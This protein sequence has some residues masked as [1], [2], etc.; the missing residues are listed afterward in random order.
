ME[1]I[2][3]LPQVE[4]F[5]ND[6]VDILFEQEYFGFQNDA[7]IYIKKIKIFIQEKI[8]VFPSKKTP[9]VLKK[10][11]ERYVTYK[12]NNRTTWYIF[13]SQEEDFY[14]IKFITNNHT[15]FIQNFNL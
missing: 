6:L 14:F 13:F 12:A 3:Y 11:G 4:I 5:L 10:F 9:E 8:S 15:D 7:E 2:I 1:K